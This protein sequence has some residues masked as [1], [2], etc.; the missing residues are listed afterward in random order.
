MHQIKG[1]AFSIVIVIILFTV[2]AVM[3]GYLAGLANVWKKPIIGAVAAFCVVTSG[4][5]TAPSHKQI[6]AVVWLIVGAISAW[7]L[8]GDSYYPEDSEHAYQLTII[9]LLATYL[10][11]IIALLIC[12]LWHKKHNKNTKKFA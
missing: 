1:F 6:A 7:I 4:Y 8:A 5:A 3:A 12:M 11:G 10:S 9:P 2:S